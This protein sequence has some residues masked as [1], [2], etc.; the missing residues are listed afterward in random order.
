MNKIFV[1]K[2]SGAHH[3]VGSSTF[4]EVF[5][6]STGIF[7]IDYTDVSGVVDCAWQR[8]YTANNKIRTNSILIL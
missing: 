2:L 6:S 8:W 5:S 3:F 4:R 7:Y 1:I